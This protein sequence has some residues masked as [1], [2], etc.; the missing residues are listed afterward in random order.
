MD[1]SLSK[2]REAVKVRGARRAAVYRV[3]RVGHDL[4]TEQ[5]QHSILLAL[6]FLKTHQQSLFHYF[7][8]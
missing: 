3:A 2:L 4:V 1:R 6:F 5:Q 7:Q 8:L